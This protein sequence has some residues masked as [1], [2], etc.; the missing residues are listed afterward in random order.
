M[1]DEQI[2]AMPARR[3]WSMERQISRIQAANDLRGINIGVAVSGKEALEKTTER[4]VLEL[5]ETSKVKRSV[6]VKGDPDRKSK[7]AKVIGS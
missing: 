4:L 6:I 5:G 2:L 3:F 7:F 1:T